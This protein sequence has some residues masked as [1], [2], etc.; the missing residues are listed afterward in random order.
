MGGVGDEGGGNGRRGGNNGFGGKNSEDALDA[1]DSAVADMG[2]AF[3][4]V[5]F[6]GL[7]VMGMLTVLESVC[8]SEDGMKI[9]V[10]QG[11]VKTL[12]ALME[13]SEEISDTRVATYTAELVK[14]LATPETVSKFVAQLSLRV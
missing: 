13:R 9:C 8:Q 1:G 4:G 11:M 5:D 12:I 10:K 7:P 6:G 3:A 14:L 2:D